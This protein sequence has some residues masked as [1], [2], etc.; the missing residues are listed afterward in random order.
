MDLEII[1][2]KEN[3]LLEREEYRVKIIFDGATPSREEIRNAIISKV[4][5]DSELLVIKK[6]EQK[7]SEKKL[8]VDVYIYKD[9]LTMKK[10][11]PFYILKRDGL[12]KEE[13]K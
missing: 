7:A 9:K 2:K 12:I 13:K 1:E 4:G 6:V 5:K 3:D 10:I 11:E 8:Y